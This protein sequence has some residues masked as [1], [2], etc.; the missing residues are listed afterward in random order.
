MSIEKIIR[1]WKADEGNREAPR[2]ASP[3]GQ[4]LTEEEVLEISGGD[5]CAL[6]NCT[7]ITCNIICGVT[8]KTLLVLSV[9]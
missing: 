3:V 6:T 1:A 7:F 8:C 9:L 5:I 4:G 2:V